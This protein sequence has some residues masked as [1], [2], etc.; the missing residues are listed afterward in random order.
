MGR[1][2]ACRLPFAAG[3]AKEAW[4]RIIMGLRQGGDEG[5]KV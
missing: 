5:V 2:A 1:F 4:R 3:A